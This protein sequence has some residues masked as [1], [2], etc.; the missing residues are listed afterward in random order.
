MIRVRLLGCL[1]LDLEAD[2]DFPSALLPH[3]VCWCSL[4]GLERND[5]PP[6]VVRFRGVPGL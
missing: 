3:G 1:P 5:L 6:Q 4:F 2:F